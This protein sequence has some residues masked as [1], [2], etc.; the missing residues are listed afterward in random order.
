MEASDIRN[1]QEAYL[2][3]YLSEERNP[4]HPHWKTNRQFKKSEKRNQELID[5]STERQKDR[6]RN[7]NQIFIGKGGK[8]TKTQREQVDLY[9]LILLHL[10]DEGYT[11]S[12][13][14]AEVILENMS[15]GWIESIMEEQK[16]LPIKKMKEKENKLE[17]KINKIHPGVGASA[18]DVKNRKE[19]NDLLKKINRQDT[20]RATRKSISK[21]GGKAPRTMED[22]R[23]G[24]YS[25]KIT[26]ISSKYYKPYPYN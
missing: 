14:G 22:M 12:I 7:K 16:P 5:A 20:I 10:L 8:I 18:F 1:L 6:A 19:R 3:I 21:R 2:D 23:M 24:S 17:D 15:E 25:L 26:P 13:E 11:N 4:S 9:D